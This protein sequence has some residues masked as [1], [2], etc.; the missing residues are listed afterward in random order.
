M[1]LQFDLRLTKKQTEVRN[2]LQKDDCRYLVIRFARQ[3]GKTTLSQVLL[4]E[5]LCN[6]RSFCGYVSPTYN[7]CQK[8]FDELVQILEPTGLLKTANNSKMQIETIFGS[9]L[10]FFTMANP[11]AIRGFTIRKGLL[12]LDECA[13]YSEILPD[14]QNPWQIL[15]PLIKADLSNNKVLML[16]TPKQKSGLFYESYCKAIQN[17]PM[18][19]SVSATI[20]DDELTSPEEIEEIRNSMSDLAFR[21]EFLC[22]FADS[23]FSFFQGYDCL[24]QDFVFDENCNCYIGIDPSGNGQDDFVLTKINVKGQ[25]QSIEITGDL[26][27]KYIQCSNIINQTRN[28]K[29]CYCEINGLGAPVYN[30]IKK[31]ISNKQIFEEFTTTNNSKIDILSDLSMAITKKELLFDRKD[32]K[33]YTQFGLFGSSYSKTGKLQLQAYGSGHDD[34]VLSLAIALAAMKKY[35][36]LG[37]YNISFGGRTTHKHK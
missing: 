20:Y 3:L 37:S 2:V 14:G 15:F 24:F 8:M 23:G 5:Y 18:W 13:Y 28:L 10:K 4:I 33:L 19:K 9:K 12:V 31:L 7:L 17:T 25:V 29:G 32:S 22:E 11:Q 27:Y 30:E 21:T 35:N 1:E 16:S 34:K 6:Y 36:V 26:D